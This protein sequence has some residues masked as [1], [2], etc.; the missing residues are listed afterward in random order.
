MAGLAGLAGLA[1]RAALRRCNRRHNV[2]EDVAGSGVRVRSGRAARAHGRR[3]GGRRR[4]DH[5]AAAAGQRA[6][7]L[8]RPL[9]ALLLA[10]SLTF[11]LCLC[12]AVPLAWHGEQA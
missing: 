5:V 9:L 11:D 12:L 10:V 4:H 8:M 2:V 3:H 1:G 6:Q 7:A